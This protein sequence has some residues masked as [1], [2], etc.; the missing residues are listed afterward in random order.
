MFTYLTCKGLKCFTS[1]EIF[2]SKSINETTQVLNDGMNAINQRTENPH[3]LLAFVV[4]TKLV[5]CCRDTLV[6][7]SKINDFITNQKVLRHVISIYR[8]DFNLILKI[9]LNWL[10]I[11]V[12]I[13]VYS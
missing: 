3:I 8:L 10:N 1:F 11:Q 7:L 12:Q 9:S 5:R 2:N 13:V 6:L 4:I